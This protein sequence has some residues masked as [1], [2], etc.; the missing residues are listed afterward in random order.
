MSRANFRQRSWKGTE[1]RNS[2][3]TSHLCPVLPHSLGVSEKLRHPGRDQRRRKPPQKGRSEGGSAH[4]KPREQGSQTAHR[5]D[6]GVEAMTPYGSP[7]PRGR[8]TDHRA[9]GRTRGRARAK[10]PMPRGMGRP[11]NDHRAE[12]RTTRSGPREQP[13]RGAGLPARSA[14]KRRRPPRADG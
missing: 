11:R 9:E 14:Q 12:A 2:G 10:G 8:T 1:R 3:A 13:R 6:K 4:R 5:T 7:G